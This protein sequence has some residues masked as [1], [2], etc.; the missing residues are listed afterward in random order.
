MRAVREEESPLVR[1]D[2]LSSPSPSPYPVRKTGQGRMEESLIL[3]S[4]KHLVSNPGGW[5]PLVT[6]RDE[7]SVP[8]SDNYV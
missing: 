4:L 6:I 8:G 7:G 2:V 3:D 1:S 5:G